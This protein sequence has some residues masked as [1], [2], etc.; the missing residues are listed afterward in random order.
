MANVPSPLVV[1]NRLLVT[2]DRGTIACFS[3]MTGQPLW[4]ERLGGNF[5]ASPTLAGDLVYLPNEAGKMFVFRAGEQYES[6]AEIDLGDG[7]F[8]SPVIVD[9]RIYLRTNRHLYCIGE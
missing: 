3:A 2:E 4:K 5:S 1:E 7:G 8:A 9:G 6:V